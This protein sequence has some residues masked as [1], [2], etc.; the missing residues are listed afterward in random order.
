MQDHHQEIK[1]I[2]Q[3]NELLRTLATRTGFFNYY[4]RELGKKDAKGRPVHRTNVECFLHCNN[5]YYELFGE[6]KFISYDS[7]R[8]AY[9]RY[10]NTQ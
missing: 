5:Q 7:F 8:M 2:R 6:E 9:T 1:K 4:F 10:L 3:E